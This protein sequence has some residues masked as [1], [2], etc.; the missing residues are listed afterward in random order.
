VEHCSFGKGKKIEEMDGSAFA[1]AMKNAELIDGAKLSS[2]GV[3]IIFAKVKEKGQRKIGYAEFLNAMA[4]VCGTTEMTFAEL[5]GKLTEA[6]VP[7][8]NVTAPPTPK[9]KE[10][11]KNKLRVAGLA[12]GATAQM[13][14]D[15]ANAPVPTGLVNE[16]GKVMSTRELFNSYDVNGDGGLEKRE[17][18]S[19][20]TD[21]E[22]LA[23][24]GP[25]EA[26]EAIDQAFAK[27]DVDGSG[28]VSF[29]E[30][31]AFYADLKGLEHKGPAP[32]PA[33]PKAAKKDPQLTAL[34]TTFAATRGQKGAVTEMDGASFSRLCRDGSIIDDKVTSTSVDIIFA[35]AKDKGKRKVDKDGF[36]RALA[37]VAAEKGVSF[38]EL[39]GALVSSV[40][41]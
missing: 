36:L 4:Q 7:K 37:L 12:S 34:F 3:D 2:T 30:F 41:G 23:A 20:L 38:E 15:V 11:F 9:K 21:L 22:V 32:P 14:E 26:S 19:F 31:A 27:A 8:K 5:A 33:I 1:R 35:R 10:V 25:K 18:S 16:A 40:L 39:T 6:G 17:I 29:E 13:V 24:L 28:M